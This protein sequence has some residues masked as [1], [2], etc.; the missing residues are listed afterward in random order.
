MTMAYVGDYVVDVTTDTFTA[1]FPTAYSPPPPVAM[2][3]TTS[4][5]GVVSTRTAASLSPARVTFFEAHAPP[6]LVR[7]SPQ[8]VSP[9][10]GTRLTLYGRNLAS[11]ATLRCGDV[12]L[13]DASVLHFG[14]AN[15]VPGNTRVIWYIGAARKGE[16]ARVAAGA[17]SATPGLQAV[18][19]I[20]L[21]SYL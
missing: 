21:K 9:E 1:G 17:A 5:V 2:T 18:P 15:R 10:G 19:A 7:V 11:T 16:A 6:V 13:Y 12:A 4:M 14:G 3:A 8:Y 20:P